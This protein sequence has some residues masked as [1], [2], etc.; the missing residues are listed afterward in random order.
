MITHRGAP[1][2]GL[3]AESFTHGAPTRQALLLP[4]FYTGGNWGS[5]KLND[6]PEVPQQTSDRAGT[7]FAL[8]SPKPICR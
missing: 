3:Y 5:E 1:Q 2:T 6:L 8:D 4:L 7:E